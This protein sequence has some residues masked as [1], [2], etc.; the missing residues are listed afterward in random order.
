MPTSR[1][2][3]VLQQIRLLQ[4][5]AKSR[6]HFYVLRVIPAQG[7]SKL[8]LQ[9]VMQQLGHNFMVLGAKE[10]YKIS[11]TLTFLVL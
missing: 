9:Q 6:E 1:V 4:L 8:A 2:K 11:R 10:S 5:A 3:S 7:Q